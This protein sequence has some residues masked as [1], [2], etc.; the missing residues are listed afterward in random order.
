MPIRQVRGQIEYIDDWHDDCQELGPI[1]AADERRPAGRGERGSE[2]T[3]HLRKLSIAVSKLEVT[4]PGVY[5]GWK[6]TFALVAKSR[7]VQ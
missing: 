3:A 2:Q 6:G 7:P 1:S 4:V 5:P